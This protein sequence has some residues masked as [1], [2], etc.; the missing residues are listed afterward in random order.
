MT[1]LWTGILRKL[2]V[3]PTE[4]VSYW[5][6]DGAVPPRETVEELALGPLLGQAIELR[7][8][9]RIECV[10]C[11]RSIK[12]TYG[13]GFCFPCLRSRPEADMCLF[14]P[15]LCHFHVEDDPC[16]DPEWGLKHCFAPHIL[17]ASLTSGVKVGIT[18]RPNVPYRWIDQGATK[19]I[20]LA[21]LPNRLEVGLVE[22]RLVASGVNDRTQW[23]RMLKG[24]T[25]AGDFEQRA[26]EL[27]ETLLRWEIEGVLPPEERRVFS[28]TYPVLEYP[29]K[30]KSLDLAKLT[31]ISGTLR[32]L[33]AQYLLLDVGV[34]NLP[35]FA[36][37]EIELHSRGVEFR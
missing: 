22:H 15:E 18:R 25:P 9:K 11:G 7:W 28:F 26:A 6:Q 35:K 16:R 14:K 30:V 32:G 3:E 21:L 5:L 36:G 31:E 29:T 33:K 12:K 19:A 37:Y 17:Y 10:A 8:T 27:A 1:L 4:P 2:R 34:I 13:Q 23:Q 24:E 20:P